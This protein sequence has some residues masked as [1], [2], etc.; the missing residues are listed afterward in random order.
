MRIQDRTVRQEYEEPQAPR[1]LAADPTGGVWIGLLNGD[2]S[3]YHD[4]RQETYRFAHDDTA[5]VNQL[6]PLSDGSILAAT[7][8]GMIGWR[9]GKLLQMTTRTACPAKRFTE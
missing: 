3:H 7:S 5:L 1:K 4:G 6:Q 8:Y 2:L 9:N